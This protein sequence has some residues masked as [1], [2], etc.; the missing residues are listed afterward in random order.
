[1]SMQSSS[2][3]KHL[4]FKPLGANP[5][6]D[7]VYAV[8]EALPRGAACDFIV[9]AVS[10]YLANHAGETIGGRKVYILPSAAGPGTEARYTAPPKKPQRAGIKKDA[11]ATPG[12]PTQ[13]IPDEGAPP[14]I[15]PKTSPAEKPD[16][17]LDDAL[18]TQLVLGF[19]NKS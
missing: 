11:A 9:T 14:L 10:E 13:E 15:A 8:L 12:T 7:A 3:T 18:L 16:T 5:A 1:M 2:R 6:H 4:G 17:E 19:N